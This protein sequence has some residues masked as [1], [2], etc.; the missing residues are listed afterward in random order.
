MSA[1]KGETITGG[2]ANFEYRGRADVWELRVR[3]RRLYG[4]IVLLPGAVEAHRLRY[5]RTSNPALIACAKLL[6]SSVTFGS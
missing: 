2:S 6:R 5:C 1:R 4:G 3:D